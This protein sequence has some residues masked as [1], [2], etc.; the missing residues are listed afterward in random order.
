MTIALL[1]DL[2]LSNC[3]C[4]T[5]KKNHTINCFEIIEFNVKNI[6]NKFSKQKKSNSFFTVRL[7]CKFLTTTKKKRIE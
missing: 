2:S 6:K 7:I 5:L 1:R 3:F 4:F